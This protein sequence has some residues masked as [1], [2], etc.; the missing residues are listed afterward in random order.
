M[1]MDEAVTA[2]L[3]HPGERLDDLQR[4]DLRIIQAPTGFCFGMD[5]V[6]LAAFAAERA[7]RERAADLGTGTGILPL[8][9][10]ARVP[11]IT[12]DAIEIQPDAADRATRSVSLN[13]LENRIAV[14]AMDLRDAPGILGYERHRLVVA[15]PPYGGVGDGPENPDAGRRISRHEGTADIDAF[16]RAAG[17]MLQNGGRFDVIFPAPRLLELMDAMRAARIEPKRIRMVHPMLG[18]APNLALVEGIKAAKPML[19]FLP[20]LYVRDENGNETEELC[21]IYQV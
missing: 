6:L 16:G 12:F 15:N 10:C 7:G 2:G 19:H 8:L 9:I 11:G 21:R 18:R 17:A 3:I 5:A 20:P 1:Q 14:H 4:G 13:G